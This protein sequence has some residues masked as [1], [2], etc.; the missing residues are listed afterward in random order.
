MVDS[1]GKSSGGGLARAAIESALRRQA[2]ALE[3]MRDAVGDAGQSGAQ[4]AGA[5][6][7]ASGDFSSLLSEGLG[8]VDA[9]IKETE[10]LHLDVLEGKLDFHEVAAK[11]KQSE[12]SFDFAM[13]VR[14]KLIDAYREVMRM[15]V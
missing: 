7:S 1:L 5:Q 15:S 9:S 13:Q 11:L 8:E 3:R 12:L 6:G 2:E 10:R 4:A 14:N